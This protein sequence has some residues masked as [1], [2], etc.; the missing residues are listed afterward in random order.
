MDATRARLRDTQELYL[1]PSTS[2]SSRHPEGSQDF[3]RLG[4]EHWSTNAQRDEQEQ[5]FWRCW[6]QYEGLKG[7]TG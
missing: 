7:E 6:S 5:G 4:L 3:T 2:D 1:H